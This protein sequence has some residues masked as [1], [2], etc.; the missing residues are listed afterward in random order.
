MGHLVAQP[1]NAKIHT[2]KDGTIISE[3]RRVNE[4]SAQG[5]IKQAGVRAIEGD[6]SIVRGISR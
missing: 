6:D 5:E 4:P 2:L 1:K 3:V